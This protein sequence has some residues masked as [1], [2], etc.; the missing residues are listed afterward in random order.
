MLRNFPTKFHCF[1]VEEFPPYYD[2]VKFIKV[3]GNWFSNFYLQFSWESAVE[4]DGPVNNCASNSFKYIQ[5]INKTFFKLI[6]TTGLTW[7]QNA[8]H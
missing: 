4:F 5:S 3:S 2:P 6:L 8:G 1:W 7:N